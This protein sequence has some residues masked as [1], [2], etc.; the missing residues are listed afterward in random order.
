MEPVKFKSRTLLP[1]QSQPITRSPAHSDHGTFSAIPN[2]M[3]Y[4]LDSIH[5]SI[6]DHLED[7]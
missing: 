2:R 3:N 6:E 5:Q 4:T 7:L 1:T